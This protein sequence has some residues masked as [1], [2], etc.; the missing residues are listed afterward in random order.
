MMRYLFLN[1]LR[2]LMP[3]IQRLFWRPAKYM[4]VQT[5]PSKKKTSY[6]GSRKDQHHPQYLYITGTINQI[7]IHAWTNTGDDL[8]SS[9]SISA[10]PVIVA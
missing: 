4:Q 7:Y 2:T 8:L 3:E 10:S 6:H 9:A 5:N 1:T